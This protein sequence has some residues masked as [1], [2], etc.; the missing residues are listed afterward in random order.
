MISKQKIKYI[1]NKIKK[2][3]AISNSPTIKYVQIKKSFKETSKNK[4]NNS[5][6]KSR[7]KYFNYFPHT[8]LNSFLNLSQISIPNKNAIKK[9]NLDNSLNTSSNFQNNSFSMQNSMIKHNKTKKSNSNSNY[10]NNYN[11]IIM[12]KNNMINKPQKILNLNMDCSNISK[13]T[14]NNNCITTENIENNNIINKLNI[15]KEIFK[16]NFLSNKNNEILKCKIVKNDNK[17]KKEIIEDNSLINAI[18]NKEIINT[19]NKFFELEEKLKLKLSENKLANRKILYNTY[20]SIFEEVIK[21]LPNNQKNLFNLIFYGYQDIILGYSN[22][23]KE[24]NEKNEKYQNR[25]KILEKENLENNVKLYNK[26]LEINEWKKKIKII[27]EKSPEQIS[28]S[29]NYSFIVTSSNNEKE[30][31][32]K[33]KKNSYIEYLNKKNYKD[34]DALYFNDKVFMKSKSKSP[35]KSNKGDI[36]PFIDLNLENKRIENKIKKININK[37]GNNNSF[38]QKVAMSFNLK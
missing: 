25:I 6:N 17:E 7:E 32:K 11:K 13:N 29:T 18:E 19:S 12:K 37:K 23:E 21:I 14:I 16:T 8:G 27:L 2:R 30:I 1:P 24:L 22:D 10:K 4:K 28:K 15:N 34:L 36:I 31:H 5:L 38:I 20:K 3:I 26:E 35:F 9:K 33:K